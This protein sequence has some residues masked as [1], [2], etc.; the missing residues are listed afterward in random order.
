MLIEKWGIFEQSFNGKS[1]GNPFVDYEIHGV[2]THEKES[3]TV[4]GFYD[5]DGIYRIRSCRLMK[6]STITRFP[7]HS[8]RKSIPES[9]PPK[10]LRGITMAP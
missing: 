9:S 3:L 2:F 4:D 8:L 1:D 6:E 5:G 7:V 10:P